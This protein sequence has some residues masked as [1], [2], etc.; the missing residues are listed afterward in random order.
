M[1]PSAMF[2][3]LRRS[4]ALMRAL[5]TYPRVIVVGFIAAAVALVLVVPD[6]RYLERAF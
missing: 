5:P 3:G 6:P 4:G 2:C 1:G